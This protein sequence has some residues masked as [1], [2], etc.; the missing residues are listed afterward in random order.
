[1]KGNNKTY[2]MLV[3]QESKGE[4]RWRTFVPL[5]HK[6][7]AMVSRQG[8]AKLRQ[9]AFRPSFSGFMDNEVGST[10]Y[11]LRSS[12]MSCPYLVHVS[13]QILSKAYKSGEEFP[14]RCL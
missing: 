6:W 1:M 11:L 3:D 7:I 14:Y 9:L 4:N 10:A 2:V 13:L 5:S 12:Y 8:L